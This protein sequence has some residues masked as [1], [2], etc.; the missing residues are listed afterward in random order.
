MKEKISKSIIALFMLIVTILPSN[1]TSIIAANNFIIVDDNVTSNAESHYFTY[2]AATDPDGLIGWGTS[3]NK[4]GENELQTQHWVWNSSNVEASKHSYTFTFQG[5]GVELVGITP[6]GSSKNTFKLDANEAQTLNID[7]TAGDKES[8]IYT[9]K[10]LPYG[11]HTV[12]VT[13][14]NDGHQTGLQIS[15]ARVYGSIEKVNEKTKIVPNKIEGSKNKFV[16]HAPTG[17]TWT[18]DNTEEAYI[19]L[20]TSNTGVAEAY[21]EIPFVGN[22]IEIYAN[23]N[24]SHGKVTFSVDGTNI[25]SADLHNASRTAPQSVYKIENLTEGEHTLKAVLEDTKTGSRFIN[26]VAYANVSHAPY[27]ATDITLEASSYSISEGATKKINY[28]VTPDYASVSDMTFT[29]DAEAIATV[30]DKGIITAKSAGTTK[31][32][33]ASASTGIAKEATVTV[34]PANPQMGG[35]IVTTDTQYTQDRYDEVKNL[36]TL[37][38]TLSGWKNDK[39]LSEISLFSKDSA[40]KNV[41]VEASDF[42][43]GSNVIKASNMK[44]TFIKSTKAYN[45]GYLGYG[46]KT[47]PVPVDNG[48][49]RSESNDI[50]Y[51]DASTPINIDFNKLQNVWVELNIPKDAAAGTY[52]GTLSVKADGISDPLTFTYTLNVE[53]ALLKDAS[54]F[55]KTFDI[56]LWQYPYSSAEYYGVEP[57]SQKHLDIM[58]S[59]MLKYKEVSGSVITASILEDAWDGQTYSKNEVHYPSMVK[60]TKNGDK[61]TYDYTDFDKWVS[62]NKGLG[63]G[64]KIVLYSIAPWHNSFTYW[65]NGTLKYERFS[66]GN[67]RYKAVWTD[68]LENLTEHL[69]EKGWYD[70]AYIGID[71]R[72]FS[73]AA[74]DVIE[75]VKN[76]HDK[77]LKTAGAMDNL[78]AHANEAMRVT[79]LTIGDTSATAHPD[80]FSQL[81][82][83]RDEAGLRTALYSCTEHQPGNF[84]L[85]SPVE[86][87]WMVANDAKIEGDGIMRWALDAWVEDP[88]NDTTHNAFEPGDCFMI[89]PDEKDAVNPTSKSSVRLEKIFEGVRDV[90]KLMQIENEIPTLKTEV[91][92]TYATISGTVAISH[93]LLS[94]EK[95]NTLI[96]QV[97]NFRDKL[98]EVT[99]RYVALKESGTDVVESVKITENSQELSLGSTLQLHAV[100]KPDNILNSGITWSSS[101]DAIAT[102][103]TSGLVTTKTMG[104]VT[105]KATSKQDATKSNEI[106]ITVGAPQIDPANQVSYYSFDNGNAD[107]E[108]GTRNGTVNGASFIDGKSKKALHV[109]GADKNVTVA[110][111]STIGENDAWS[112]NYWVNSTAPLNDRSSVLMDKN[113]DYSADLKLSSS[114]ADGGF[115]V[116]KG[117]GDVLTYQYPFKQ[118]EWYNVCWTQNKAKG[119]SMY[120]NGTLVKTIDWTKTHKVLAPLDIIGGTGFVGYIDEVKVFNKELDS[121]EIA[122]AMIVKGLNLTETSKNLFVGDSYKIQTNLISDNPDKTITY[123]SSNPEI[124]TVDELG[125]VQALKRGNITISVENTAGG[126]KG[127]VTLNIEKHLNI[128][129]KLTEH[130]LPE[131]NLTDVEKAPGTDRQYLGQP[132]MVRTKTGRLITSYPIGHGKGPLVMKIS[133]D[134]GTTWT[135]KTDIPTSW[136]GSQE[137]PTMYTLDLGNDKERIILITA[138]PGWGSDSDGNRTGWNT[139]YSDDNGDTWNEYKHWYTNLSDGTANKSIVGMAS[140]IQL[141]DEN[142][143]YIQKWMGVYHNYG[144]ENYKTYLTF[145]ENGNEQW[146]EPEK[147]LS[148][149]RNIESRYQICEV[150]MFR[151]PDGK[152]IVGL[153]R[154]QSHNNPATLIYSDDEGKTWSKPMDLPGSLAGERH[155]AAY[156]PI[157]GRLVITFREIIY[158]LNGDNEFGGGNDWLAGE[159]VA[160]VGTY[161]DLLQQNEGEYRIVLAEDWANNA[162]SGD[163]G[164]AG[165]VVLQDGTFI[166]DSYGHWDK[167]FSQSWTGGVTKD[168]CYIKQAKFKLAEMDNIAGL[169]KRTDLEASINEAGKI[170]NESE[171]EA[172]SWNNFKEALKV[173]NQVLADTGSDQKKI[174]NATSALTL[175]MGQLVKKEVVN[176]LLLTAAVTKADQLV[177]DGKLV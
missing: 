168:L 34:I 172:N 40:L 70:D 132:D 105:I 140:L 127:T 158:D 4:F 32:K 160:W 159:W 56:E 173:A 38:A 137:T 77:H 116:G 103:S 161:D 99:K 49:N 126:F 88:L 91:D 62:F 80:E 129:N 78:S 156:D 26:Q 69:M 123:T 9:V 128:S 10:N 108:W 90:N 18:H 44:S 141:K 19:D 95:I 170:N 41:I 106:T 43:S 146:S 145:D 138:C 177:A 104:T 2:T 93:N 24:Y 175:S 71:E 144:Y 150:G 7:A 30:S 37:T 149:Y 136:A 86:G 111:S 154:S 133:D 130:K 96:G 51:Q 118:N 59:G 81:V 3:N 101:S 66:P 36:G 113:K 139:S 169:I 167:E 42:T 125:N 11:S 120:V 74:F 64:D 151:S 67:D 92:A 79:D 135:E 55:K 100:V 174:D 25:K 65:E 84:S 53:N 131:A 46:S 134:E 114:R 21:Y 143:N 63:I 1:L 164:Y 31:I 89:Y 8:V 15:Y 112:I 76:I 33:I 75:S 20:G 6:T 50:L 97:S 117:N 109:T 22:G 5:T 85:S 13:L 107:D 72:G 45:G 16:Y 147:Y 48:T 23:K 152:R 122:A 87:Y 142:G 61:F 148:E 102:V 68:F 47:R 28:T 166:M 12:Q 82:K 171:Y 121:T 57:F 35:S 27:L 110:G 153:A 83:R 124:A 39:V 54:E 115:H 58:E 98:T 73:A 94:K 176:K 165:V 163:T 119:L 162:K 17:K 52:T 29:S 60:W 14:P 155:K 157:T